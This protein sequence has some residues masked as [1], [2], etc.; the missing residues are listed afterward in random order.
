MQRGSAS[1]SLVTTSCSLPKFLIWSN[2][3]LYKLNMAFVLNVAVTRDNYTYCSCLFLLFVNLVFLYMT[4][5]TYN[6][7][8]NVPCITYLYHL[9]PHWC[10][11][12]SLGHLY[13]A[14]SGG[15]I[16]CG[17]PWPLL[18]LCWMPI[19]V[20]PFSPGISSH[21]FGWKIQD[22]LN[23]VYRSNITGLAVVLTE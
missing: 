5:G 14:Y 21:W 3:H 8:Y 11:G 17:Q 19:V 23:S 15:P 9:T 18:L 6:I 12:L 16:G 20:L 10:V 2:V 1:I 7:F 4:L 22:F 13:T